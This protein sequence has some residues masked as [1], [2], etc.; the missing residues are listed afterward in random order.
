[1][2]VCFGSMSLTFF[3]LR[4]DFQSLKCYLDLWLSSMLNCIHICVFLIFEKL[5]LSNLNSCW[6]PLDSYDIYRALSASFYRIIDSFSIHQET[7]WM[8]DSF[9]IHQDP[10]SCIIFSHVLHLSFILSSIASLF[11]TF[12]HLYGFL[13]PPWSSLII[14]MFLGWSFL[15]SCTLCQSWQK[16]GEIVEKMWFLFKILHVRGEIHAFVRGRC[17][18]SC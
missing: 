2:C 10:L 3:L 8:L 4:D 15:T 7:F 9:L 17:V 5:L 18:S 12:T 11:I 6:T 14:F 16:G 13:M 1:M